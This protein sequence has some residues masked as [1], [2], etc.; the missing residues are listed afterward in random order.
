MEFFNGQHRRNLAHL[1]LTLKVLR[2]Q[3]DVVGYNSF[4][5][6]ELEL[7]V[8]M[9]ILGSPVQESQMGRVVEQHLGDS[10]IYF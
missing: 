1:F 4:V 5:E 3:E 8:V 7:E 9:T 6:S 2:V 10:G